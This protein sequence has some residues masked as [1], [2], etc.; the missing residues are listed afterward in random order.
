MSMS[1]NYRGKA[2]QPTGCESVTDGAIVDR[3]QHVGLK[4]VA[5][6]AHL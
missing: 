2:V 5:E 4:R 6:E 1:W 3:W